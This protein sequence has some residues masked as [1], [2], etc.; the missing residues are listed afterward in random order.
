M[1]NALLGMNWEL[2]NRY[3]NL[4]ALNFTHNAIMLDSFDILTP[5][6]FQFTTLCHL[7]ND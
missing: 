1:Y 3:F 7:N 6:F 5:Q 2:V 4:L